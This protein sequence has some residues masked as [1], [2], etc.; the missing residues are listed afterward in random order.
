M[1]DELLK[2]LGAASEARRRR[3]A[4]DDMPGQ[5]NSVA[6]CNAEMVEVDAVDA[7]LS[8]GDR[9]ATKLRQLMRRT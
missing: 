6:Y 3:M 1:N 9:M 8:Y 4:L 7:L 2:L 5:G